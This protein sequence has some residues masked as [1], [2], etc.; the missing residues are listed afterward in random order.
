MLKVRREQKEVF[1]EVAAKRFEDRTVQ[2]VKEFFPKHCEILGEGPVRQV[3]RRGIERAEDHGLTSE[4]DV[5]LYIGL[6]FMLGS[7]FDLDPQL[8]WAVE[9]LDD[10]TTGNPNLR[11]NRVYDKAM[12]YL[13]KVAGPNS[14]HLESALRR[15]RNGP[16]PEVPGASLGEFAEHMLAQLEATYPEKHAALGEDVLR[17]LIAD[18]YEAARGYRLASRRG[19]TLYVS[20]MFMLGSGFDDDPQYPWAAAVLGDEGA[21]RADDKAERLHAEA[22]AHLEKW[23]A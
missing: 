6:M 14:E 2:H 7:N 21:G 15:L 13:D 5:T 9:I 16:I 3:I 19:T 12:A 18:G 11:A 22:M 10:D 23:L 8:P 17:K 20:L 4:R 1:G